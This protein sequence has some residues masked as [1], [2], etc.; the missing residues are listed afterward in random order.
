MFYLRLGHL[1]QEVT[2]ADVSELLVKYGAIEPEKVFFGEAGGGM[3]KSIS[4]WITRASM[5]PLP[6]A[7]MQ[8]SWPS[9]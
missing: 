5:P 4:K 1:P 2:A 6:G 7:N 9:A 8:T 3:L